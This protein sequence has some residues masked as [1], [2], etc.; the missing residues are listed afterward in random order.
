MV[1]A[2][3]GAI[4]DVAVLAG[5]LLVV[6]A[7]VWGLIGLLIMRELSGLEFVVYLCGLLVA[8]G[9]AVVMWGSSLSAGIVA[10]MVVIGLGFP[11]ARKWANDAALRRM[12]R[13]DIARQHKAIEKRPEIPYA[14]RKLG[15]IYYKRGQ[16]DEA[17]SWYKQ[18]QELTQ[19][20]EVKF[21]VKRS[22]ELLETAEQ[23]TRL[24]PDC[25]HANPSYARYCVN[26]GSMLPGPWEIVQAFRGRAGLRYLATVVV[27]SL[28]I[29]TALALLLGFVATPYVT[30]LFLIAAAATVYILYKRFTTV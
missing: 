4:V 2:A 8:A 18:Y 22:L 7:V 13:E 10:G 11:Q 23:M 29:G 14:Y 3:G 26:C 20:P 15:D 6:G 28:A 5:A 30:C 25:H 27:A 16:W 17:V 21:R 9:A 1:G 19:D 24:C 12:E